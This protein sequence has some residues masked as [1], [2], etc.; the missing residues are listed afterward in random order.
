MIS[1]QAKGN[2][3]VVRRYG[4]AGKAPEGA[5]AGMDTLPR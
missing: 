4:L 3:P 1:G 5:W 2:T